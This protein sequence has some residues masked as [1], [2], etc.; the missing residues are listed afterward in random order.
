MN[1][2]LYIFGSGVGFGLLLAIFLGWSWIALEREHKRR[3]VEA[4][5]PELEEELQKL[6][7]FHALHINQHD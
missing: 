1:P 3:Q 7:A 5:K 4:Q 2:A 6:R